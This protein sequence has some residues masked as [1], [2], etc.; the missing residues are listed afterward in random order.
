MRI[1]RRWTSNLDG[2]TLW[3]CSC[4]GLVQVCCGLS[5][6]PASVV[7][8]A[9]SWHSH[10]ESSHRALCIRV[11]FVS[12]QS[13]SFCPA[14]SHSHRWITSAQLIIAAITVEVAHHEQKRKVLR[15]Q[16][17]RDNEF[18]KVQPHMYMMECSRYSTS[19]RYT[20]AHF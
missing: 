7:R 20:H 1:T 10:R 16:T 13:C 19:G 5:V 8:G 11:S 12:H 2:S 6:P 18:L 17:F 14:A 9:S 4:I 3:V 15:F